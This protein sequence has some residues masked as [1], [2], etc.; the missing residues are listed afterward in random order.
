MKKSLFFILLSLIVLSCKVRSF[1]QTLDK[2]DD[3]LIFGNG[4]GFTG[5]YK[6]YGLDKSGR[7]YKNENEVWKYEGKIPA[8]S[9]EQSFQNIV[10]LGLLEKPKTSPGNRYYTLEY[11]REGKYQKWVW[12]NNPE[13]DTSLQLMYDIL[14][15]LISRK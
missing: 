4:G 6:S 14:L 7:I 1:Q 11:Q 8:N 5:T 10:Q 2:G 13:G 12:G 9:V 15:T 3:Y